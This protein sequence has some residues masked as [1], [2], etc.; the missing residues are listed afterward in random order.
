LRISLALGVIFFIESYAHI[1]PSAFAR[2]RVRSLIIG[3][4]ASVDNEKA[5][6]LIGG[7]ISA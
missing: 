6:A 5:I 4:G 2:F 1:R 3:S 7:G